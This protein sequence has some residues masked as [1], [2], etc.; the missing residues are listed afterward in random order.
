IAR[1]K[2]YSEQKAREIDEAVQEILSAAFD[3][4][5]RILTEH[6]DQVEKLADALVERETLTDAE[7]REL[8][9]FESRTRATD[10]LDR[11]EGEA[12]ADA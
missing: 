4:A 12:A 7:V 9:G 5:E 1:H 2:D 10:L 6:R 11:P 3:D 8:L